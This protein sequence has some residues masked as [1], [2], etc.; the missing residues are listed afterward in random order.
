VTSEPG[1]NAPIHRALWVDGKMRGGHD[2]RV[3]TGLFSQLSGRGIRI[4]LPVVQ[5]TAKFL[6]TTI[7]QIDTFMN[8]FGHRSPN[9]CADLELWVHDNTVTGDSTYQIEIIAG[10]SGST[11]QADGNSTFFQA[12]LIRWAPAEL[13]LPAISAVTSPWVRLS[14]SPL[15]GYPLAS[16]TERRRLLL[17]AESLGCN[18]GLW[19]NERG[20]ALEFCWGSLVWLVGGSW[21]M[22]S[23]TM[24]AT[25]NPVIAEIYE[26]LDMNERNIETSELLDAELVVRIGSTGSFSPI[27]SLDGSQLAMRPDATDDLLNIMN[28]LI[29]N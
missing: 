19:I 7:L 5:R 14:A 23:R 9:V 17:H 24:H 10:L 27:A 25:W 16:G 18:E 6:D 13:M 12:R 4:V 29:L 8:L 20:H 11:Y 15:A 26:L 22:P 3:L 1:G 21:Y 28:G 2:E